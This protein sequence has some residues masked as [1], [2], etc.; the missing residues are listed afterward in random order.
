M[1]YPMALRAA[2]I[3]ATLG[4]GA[5][6]AQQSTPLVMSDMAPLPAEERSSTGAILLENSLVRAQRDR[7]FDASASRT[8]VGSL[9]RGIMRATLHEQ[10]K[11]DLAQAREERALEFYR[12]GAGS[13][14]K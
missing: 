12:R 1:K 8:G 2:L 7:D 6:F 11:A 5:A 3:A 14:T 10:T 9:G 13:L 4:A